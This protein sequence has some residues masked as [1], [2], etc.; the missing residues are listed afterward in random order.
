MVQWLSADSGAASAFPRMLGADGFQMLSGPS[1]APTL[2]TRCRYQAATELRKREPKRTQTQSTIA[3]LERTPGLNNS[4]PRLLALSQTIPDYPRLSGNY[5][6]IVMTD[7]AGIRRSRRSHHPAASLKC[8]TR[9]CFPCL[10]CFFLNAEATTLRTVR[11]PHGTTSCTTHTTHT[12]HRA[13][14]HHHC[15][16]GAWTGRCCFMCC[17][18]TIFKIPLAVLEK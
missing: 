8:K 18:L 14:H 17:L 4:D 3:R 5:P 2:T 9:V 16:E 10:V 1:D 12:T 7:A 15:L 13:P 11:T 6:G